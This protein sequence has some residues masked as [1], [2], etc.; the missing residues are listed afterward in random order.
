MEISKK[1]SVILDINKIIQLSQAAKI[2]ENVK[3][4]ETCL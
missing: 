1:F 3:N 2:L 4:D